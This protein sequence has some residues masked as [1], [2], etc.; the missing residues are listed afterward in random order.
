MEITEII[1]D[2][3]MCPGFVYQ[4]GSSYYF[5]GKWICRPCTDIDVTDCHAMYDICI[6]AGEIQNA[7]YYFQKLRAYSDFALEVP[8]NPQKT[9]EDLTRLLEGLSSEELRSLEKQLRQFKEI[10]ILP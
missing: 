2:L 9:L 10:N 6:S 3:K 5:L 1:S 7:R 4:T 8:C